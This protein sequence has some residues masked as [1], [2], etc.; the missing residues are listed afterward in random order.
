MAKVT[1]QLNTLLNNE[2]AAN[3]LLRF[4]VG[5]I[6]T[7]VLVFLKMWFESYPAGHRAEFIT[8]EFLKSWLSPFASETDMPVVI[9]DISKVPG[10]K[11]GMITPRDTLEKIIAE[12]VNQKARAIAIDVDF[13]PNDNGWI[14]SK[15]DPRFFKFC[16]EQRQNYVPVLLGVSRTSTQKPEHWL[17]SDEFKDLAADIFANEDDT[18]RLLVWSQNGEQQKLYSMSLG[19]VNAV[20]A[21]VKKPPAW[22]EFALEGQEHIEVTGKN[23]EF[24]SA[25][26][27]VNYSKLD[28]LRNQALPAISPGSIRDL[29]SKF[30]DKIVIVGDATFGEATDTFNVPGSVRPVPGVYLHA[31]SV[32]SLMV[33][34]LYELK[35]WSKIVIDFSLGFAIL[36]IITIM[37]WR[38]G[39]RKIDWEKKQKRFILLAVLSCFITGILSVKFLNILWLDFGLVIFALLLHP[40]VEDVIK[41][42]LRIKNKESN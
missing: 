41:N 37:R 20:G 25:T 42:L 21:E 18:S 24:K 22:L 15:N 4:V 34:P 32:Y 12:L 16:L 26:M 29:G 10:G 13:S 28:T 23:G 38:N 27:L 8:Y 14:D 5:I 7:L 2:N 39:N 31:S 40:A 19:L 3:I 17:G 35:Y 11:A 9:V 1:Q 36:L 33:E 6:A 30:K